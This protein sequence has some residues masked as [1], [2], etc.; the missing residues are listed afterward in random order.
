MHCEFLLPKEKKKRSNQNILHVK[1]E[2]AAVTAM[3]L[4]LMNLHFVGIFHNKYG[5]YKILGVYV[6]HSGRSRLPKVVSFNYVTLYY[7]LLDL[8]RTIFCLFFGISSAILA[9]P[10]IA[11]FKVKQKCSHCRVF[12]LL[13]FFYDYYLHITTLYTLFFFLPFYSADQK[14]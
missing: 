8:V 7:I 11:L 2:I 10:I 3:L 5:I 12:I 1:L 14:V 13:N 9:V 6:T 4:S